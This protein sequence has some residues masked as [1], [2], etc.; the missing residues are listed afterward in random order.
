MQQ[1]MRYVSDN[2]DDAPMF[3]ESSVTSG[4]GFCTGTVFAGA[5]CPVPYRHSDMAEKQP[6]TI[7]AMMSKA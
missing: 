2:D 7:R 1:R 3:A 4:S 6:T 5:H